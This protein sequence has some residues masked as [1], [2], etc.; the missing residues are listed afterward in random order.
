MKRT[1][2]WLLSAVLLLSGCGGQPGDVNEMISQPEQNGLLLEQAAVTEDAQFLLTAEWEVYD[3]S[4]EEIW[5]FIENQSGGDAA[6]GQAYALEKWLDGCGWYRVPF[7][8][9][10]GWDDILYTLAPGGKQ[11]ACC[12]LS[13]FNYSFSSGDCLRIVKEIEGQTCAAEFRLE[14]GAAVSAQTPYGFGP[15]EDLPERY[16]AADAAGTGAVI[17]TDAGAENAEAVGTFLEKVSLGVPCQLRTV[18]D[19]GES[20]PMV[21]DVIYENDCFLWRMRSGGTEVAER[22]LSYIVT[23]GSD[24]YLSD[25][26]DWDA[27]E[28]YGD[29]RVFLVPPLQGTEWVPDV[30]AMTAD[31]L[32]WNATRYQLRSADGVW[33]AALREESTAFSVSWQKPGEGSGSS[34]YDLADW[35]G[36]ETAII[37]ISWREDGKLTLKCETSDG[38]TSRLTFD[39]ETETLA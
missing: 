16:G 18:Q 1:Y 6:F 28:R 10:T 38:G 34:T 7:R 23:D 37:G 21:I 35:D 19:H 20:I 32:A 9:G 33:C 39:P 11:A 29:Q 15:L 36:L 2:L 31:R 22:R 14:E 5:F 12:H 17:F 24:L 3:P 25:G 13:L 8:E 27:G 26:A 30:E 4:A